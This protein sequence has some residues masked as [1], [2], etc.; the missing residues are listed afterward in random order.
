[1]FPQAGGLEIGG[2]NLTSGAPKG[3]IS[4]N[5]DGSITAAGDLTVGTVSS[6][7]N[8]V[9]L[10]NAAAI[11][12]SDSDS[13]ATG[14][15]FQ[16]DKSGASGVIK[17][18]KDGSAEFKSDV[19]SR[20][21][22]TT[23]YNTDIPADNA[24][25]N[26]FVP[27]ANAANNFNF[28][29]CSIP[30]S[31]DKFVV[32]KNGSATFSGSITAA[33]SVGIGTDDPKVSLDVN[34]NVLTKANSFISSNLYYSGGWKYNTDGYGG[35]IK[36]ANGSI[37]GMYFGVCLDE[38]ASGADAAADPQTALYISKEGSAT[39][40]GNVVVSNDPLS[41]DAAGIS[42]DKTGTVVVG[43]SAGTVFYGVNTSGG[44]SDVTTTIEADGS[45]SFKGDVTV[46]DSTPWSSA[47]R[48]GTHMASAGSIETYRDVNGS[49]N[50]AY[51]AY[52][53]NP[54][55]S[56]DKVFGVN[57][58]G[59]AV[60]AGDVTA[61]DFFDTTKDGALLSSTGAVMARQTNGAGVL[62]QGLRGNT[63]TS[64]LDGDGELTISGTVTAN[65]T[66]LTRANGNLDVG[67]RL[68]KADN[69]LQILKTAAAAASD[70]A[71]LKA[72]IATALANI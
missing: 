72:A 18:N 6:S 30:G 46:G 51:A 71:A 17:L 7:T 69:A 35:Y 10:D 55:G 24:C 39:F 65:G 41:V 2:S 66:V 47:G 57:M 40:A 29:R 61:G 34:G 64:K 12:V 14:P 1:M 23:Y 56:N 53:K 5:D 68:E 50:G 19:L 63:Q 31:S 21:A 58:D 27:L 54:N 32:D 52:Y 15:A 3:N 25:I 43:N 37:G 22:L 49:S 44:T 13:A 42:L 9:Y 4:L 36:I 59:S 20:T 33:G 45:A 62:W 16:V 70:F 38:N 67:D 48:T 11:Y 26:A 8:Y 28:I 60:F